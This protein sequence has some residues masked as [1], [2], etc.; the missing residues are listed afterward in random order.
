MIRVPYPKPIRKRPRSKH[1]FQP[2]LSRMSACEPNMYCDSCMKEFEDQ[3]ESERP[4][5]VWAVKDG[6]VVYMEDMVVEH[7]LG[8]PLLPTEAVLHRNGNLFDN[9]FENL[10]VITI[11][12]LD[13]E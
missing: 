1:K 8:R 3:V 6:K 12:K 7:H 10:E 9:R 11:E 4:G 5:H 2:I 13:T